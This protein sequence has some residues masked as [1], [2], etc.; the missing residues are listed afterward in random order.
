MAISVKHAAGVLFSVARRCVYMT[1]LN[2][3]LPKE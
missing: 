1:Y 3:D 2:F